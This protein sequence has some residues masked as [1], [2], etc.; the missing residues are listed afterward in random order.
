MARQATSN[1]KG[2]AITERCKTRAEVFKSR[3]RMARKFCRTPR[4]VKFSRHL[5]A[6]DLLPVLLLGLGAREH[7]N[8][9]PRARLV[10]SPREK[11]FQTKE[12][13][14]RAQYPEG[15]HSVESKDLRLH[16]NLA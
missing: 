4:R 12:E 14:S 3:D 10:E 6:A 5:K 13:V 16:Q 1:F 9:A 11:S 2:T 7:N 8:L 15:V